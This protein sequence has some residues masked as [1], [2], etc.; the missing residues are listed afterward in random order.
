MNLPCQKAHFE[1]RLW[2]HGA[3]WPQGAE[4]GAAAVQGA[5]GRDARGHGHPVAPS[6]IRV[7]EDG[8]T[9]WLF[10]IAMV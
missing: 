5:E 3:L 4:R 7:A 1:P 9:L 8:D 6:G 2:A 10:N